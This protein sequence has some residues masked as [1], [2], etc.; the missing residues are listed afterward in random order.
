MNIKL[1]IFSGVITAAIGTVIGLSA[2]ELA[3]PKFE[4]SIYKNVAPKYAA[5]GGIIGLLAGAGQESIRQ[6]KHQ[7]DKEEETN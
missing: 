6:L 1:I 2:S 7:R 3:R 4:S 5:A